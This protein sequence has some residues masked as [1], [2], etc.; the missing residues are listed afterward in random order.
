MGKK[1]VDKNVEKIQKLFYLGAVVIVFVMAFMLLIKKNQNDNL[2]D[3]VM[4]NFNVKTITGKQL[5]V[6]DLNYTYPKYY[7][8]YFGPSDSFDVH[9]FNYYQNKGQ[10][11]SEFKSL[12]NNIIDYNNNKKM[13]RV[14]YTRGIGSYQKVLDNLTTILNS[15]NLKVM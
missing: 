8:I 6:K 3:V 11:E 10:Y 12:F 13:I 9:A 4:D 5:V 14:L 2:A 7:V 15:N 1:K